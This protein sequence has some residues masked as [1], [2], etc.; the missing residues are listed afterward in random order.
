MKRPTDVYF[1]I[2]IVAISYWFLGELYGSSFFEKIDIYILIEYGVLLLLSV[3]SCYLIR[4]SKKITYLKWLALSIIPGL[5]SMTCM[6]FD[7]RSGGG[8]V[9]FPWDFSLWELIIPIIYGGIQII[10]I[11]RHTL[12][13]W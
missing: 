3:I 11:I 6:R 9:S 10:F 5:L 1:G 2:P 4:N 12:K 8:W 7:S 13:K